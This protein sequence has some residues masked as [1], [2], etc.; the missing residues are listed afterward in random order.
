MAFVPS[1]LMLA[2]TTKTATDLGS[3]PLFWVVPL[4]LY[5]LTFVLTFTNRPVIGPQMRL[6]GFIIGLTF[7]AMIFAGLLPLSS[8]RLPVVGLMTL[9]FFAVSLFAHGLLYDGR[10]AGAH[11]TLFYIVMSVG[12]AL[13]GLFNSILAP[14]LFSGPYEGAV[15]V[16][17]AALLLWR[18]MRSEGAA[19]SR[20]RVIGASLVTAFAFS[21]PLLA[22]RPSSG[23]ELFRDRSFFGSHLVRDVAGIRLYQNGTTVHGAQHLDELGASRP[24]PMTYYGPNGPMA[25]VLTSER[26]TQAKHVGIVGLGV[27]SLAC[28]RQPGQD[29]HFYEIDGMVDDVARDPALFSFMSACAGD[30]PT[31]LGDARLVLAQQQDIRF[32]VLIIDAYSSDAVPVH[33][34]TTEAMQLYLDRL[35]PGG[36][37]VY[38]ITNRHFD[39]RLPLAR[40]AAS[41][42][43]V[44]LRQVYSGTAGQ[45][46]DDA[47]SEVVLIARDK[48]ALGELG[49]DTRWS[50]LLSDGGRPWTDDYA[51]VLSILFRSAR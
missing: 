51:N 29:W 10:P 39:I 24:S 46:L 31:H 32:D 26:G 37:L 14:V 27:G 49:A 42:G 17:V 45:G 1:S 23:E 33:L 38:H 19:S 16:A 5:L 40:S 48:A 18:V 21:T 6:A 8:F 12:G 50:P 7:L 3:I 11:L 28:Y 20:P 44:A 35:T 47:R 15:T 13:G 43:L 9:A 22:L 34:T 41:L 4:A 30:A 2:V 36:L 25:Q